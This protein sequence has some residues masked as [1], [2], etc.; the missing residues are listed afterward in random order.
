VSLSQ[1]LRG[2]AGPGSIGRYGLIGISGV[3]LDFVLFVVLTRLGVGPL[4]ATVMSTL[5]GI[6]NNYVLNARLNFGTGVALSSGW[7]FLAVGLVGLLV[8]AWSLDLLLRAGLAEL[9]AKLISV[10]CVVAAQ[11][12]ANRYWS[13]RA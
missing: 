13:F 5:A 10:P 3:T 7:R 8:A 12:V 2:L 4:P 6:G 1:R 11:Y 9:T